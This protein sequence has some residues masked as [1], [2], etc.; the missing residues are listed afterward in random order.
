MYRLRV[1]VVTISQPV[2]QVHKIWSHLTRSLLHIYRTWS[3]DYAE[4]SFLS[5]QLRF[6][7][8]TPRSRKRQSKVWNLSKFHS[9]FFF[10]N[11]RKESGCYTSYELLYA[12][13]GMLDVSV[14]TSERMY[15]NRITVPRKL[16]LSF[17]MFLG[18]MQ[19]FRRVILEAKRCVVIRSYRTW[20]LNVSDVLWKKWISGNRCRVGNLALCKVKGLSE[21]K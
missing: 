1:C 11:Y 18:T 19:N 20:Q 3:K 2:P 5:P 10:R 21:P 8:C 13:V 16:N 14:M 17:L 15:T 9:R 4:F 6:D 12:R 7:S